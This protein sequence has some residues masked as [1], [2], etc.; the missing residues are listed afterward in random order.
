LDR[1]QEIIDGTFEVFEGPIVDQDGNVL[2]AEGVI[3][4]LGELLGTEYLVDNVI[5]SPTAGG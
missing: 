3:A 5:G 4:P 2:Y 1:K